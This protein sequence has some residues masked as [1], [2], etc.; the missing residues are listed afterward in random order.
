MVPPYINVI[1]NHINIVTLQFIVCKLHE[2]NAKG[3]ILLLCSIQ[4]YALSK[5]PIYSTTMLIETFVFCVYIAYSQYKKFWLVKT[6]DEDKTVKPHFT[7][8]SESSLLLFNT[9]IQLTFCHIHSLEE[10]SIQHHAV[11]C[12]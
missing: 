2:A 4:L 5:N 10:L 11:S 7:S 12:F 1:T 8:T 9:K 3:I 6:N